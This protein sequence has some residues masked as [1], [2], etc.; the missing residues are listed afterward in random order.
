MEIYAND[1][2]NITP[3]KYL[4]WYLENVH[5]L[6]FTFEQSIGMYFTDKGVSE[7]SMN[8]ID[9]LSSFINI[10]IGVQEAEIKTPDW[11]VSFYE[12]HGH[13]DMND[14]DKVIMELAHQISSQAYDD[15]L[16]FLEHSSVVPKDK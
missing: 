4:G 7:F 5:R 15:A 13:E 3:I 14:K 6:P 16:E 8:D 2:I 10:K 12:S 9:Y 11:I 1:L